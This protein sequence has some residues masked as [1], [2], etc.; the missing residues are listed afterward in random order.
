M[1]KKPT[2]TNHS[3]KTKLKNCLNIFATN[4]RLVKGKT[5]ELLYETYQ[6]DGVGL[7]DTYLDQAIPHHQIFGYCRKT[8][9]RKDRNLRGDGVL[10]AVINLLQGNQF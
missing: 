7:T 10:I 4:T 9:W 3:I 2:T 5:D 6:Y 1:K 8:I